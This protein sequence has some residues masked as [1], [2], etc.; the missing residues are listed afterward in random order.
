MLYVEVKGVSSKTFDGLHMAKETLALAVENTRKK[1]ED[2]V[3]MK[4]KEGKPKEVR[5]RLEGV[6]D[7]TNCC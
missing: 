3:K 4:D 6:E 2:L 1:M 5:S 7:R